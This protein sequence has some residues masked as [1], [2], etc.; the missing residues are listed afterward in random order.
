MGSMT[1]GANDVAVSPIE[2][3][4]LTNIRHCSFYVE[5]VQVAKQ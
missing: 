4:A 2:I 5:L 3:L 1:L